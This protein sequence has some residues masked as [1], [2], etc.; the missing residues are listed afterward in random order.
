MPIGLIID[1][2]KK[3]IPALA[4]FSLLAGGSVHAQLTIEI[5]GTGANRIPIA[6]PDF[7]GDPANARALVSVL[8]S[9][10]ETSGQFKL[11]ASV[12]IP[13]SRT[14][15]PTPWWPAVWPLPPRGGWKRVTGS[16][17]LISVPIFRERLT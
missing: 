6:V 8:R 2:M 11:V 9:D 12:I 14:R 7:G 10:L 17:T 4:L 15:A 5:A 3:L 16:T 1:T 13:V